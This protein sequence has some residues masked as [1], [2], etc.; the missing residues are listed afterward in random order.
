MPPRLC[1]KYIEAASA[2][3]AYC[4]YAPREDVEVVR[5]FRLLAQ[6]YLSQSNYNLYKT[7]TD[8][9]ILSAKEQLSDTV[10]AYWYETLKLA[11]FHVLYGSEIAY[12]SKF[13]QVQYPKFIKPN[14][15]VG[16]IYAMWCNSQLADY[17]MY[18]DQYNEAL[19]SQIMATEAAKNLFGAISIPYVDA[20]AKR[21]ELEIYSG[22]YNQASVSLAEADKYSYQTKKNDIPAL[23]QAHLR[24]ARVYKITGNPLRSKKHVSEV[25]LLTNLLPRSNFNMEVLSNLQRALASYE[26][27]NINRADRIVQSTKVSTERTIGK[28]QRILLDIYLL[29]AE[30]GLVSGNFSKTEGSLKQA[31]SLIPENSFM[32][33]NWLML[34]SDY[35]LAISDVSKSREYLSYSDKLVV[36]VLGS[37][38]LFRTA[39]LT[40]QAAML[41][42]STKPDVQ[43]I[44]KLYIQA[45]IIAAKALGV[46]NPIFIQIQQK[47]AE[48]YIQIGQYDKANTILEEVRKFWLAMYGENHLNV[49]STVMLLGKVYYMQS[50]YEQAATW[51]GQSANIYKSIF[52]TEHPEYIKAQSQLA[53]VAYM[54][55]DYGKSVN[56]M[57]D[58][59]PKCLDYTKKYFPNLSF[60][61]KS[62]FWS[63]LKDD[64][65]FYTFLV[66]EKYAET[67]P[68]LLGVLY[69]TVIN[70]KAL[71]LSSDIKLRKQILSSKDLISSSFS[72]SK[73]ELA[74][75]GIYPDKLQSSLEELE[76]KMSARSE[77]FARSGKDKI[78]SWEDIRKVLT[79]NEVS[80]EML[81]YRRF[82]K[83]FTDTAYYAELVLTAERKLSPD[84]VRLEEG[85]MLEK[86]YLKYYRNA[87]VT[88]S[89]DD[90]SYD[91]FWA[92]I[93]AKL[94]DG[95]TVYFSGEGVY[96]QLNVET[97]I[98]T[99]SG[100]YVLEQNNVVL[101]TNTKDL[102]GQV[103]PRPKDTEVYADFVVSGNTQFYKDSN[104]VKKS[105]D[106]L[107]GAEQEA[108]LV[109]EIIVKSGKKTVKM[110]N[111]VVTEDTI[112]SIKNPT[113]FHI[114]THGFFKESVAGNED[115]LSSN[116]LINSGLM[117]T[118][119]GDIADNHDN[120][121]VN[122]KEGIL[123][124]YESLDLNF[125]HTE[126][127]VLSACETG[128]GDVQLGEEVYGLQ[129]SFLVAGS[130]AI[131]LSLFKV[132]D[133][134]TQKLMMTFYTNWIRTGNMRQSFIDA[135]KEV[136]ASYPQ[137]I[138]WGAFVL[139]ESRPKRAVEAQM[140]AKK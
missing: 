59:V 72:L 17:Y 88:K 26:T 13:F 22:A 60:R 14:L 20:L 95:Y 62:K 58:I 119:S 24:I 83:V 12:A 18:K 120:G 107:A 5:I 140:W 8:S 105:I 84:F 78:I 74:E 135:K 133:E 11:S 42:K 85:S 128:R 33:S 1:P 56:L 106:N 15:T 2:Q 68:D 99:E 34:Q 139:I 44:E 104:Q 92:P 93:K 112:K 50:K 53:R 10:P 81:R 7:Y 91:Q 101:V 21:S 40:R 25:L 82:N 86:R 28:D 116:P 109:E 125:D 30:T 102:V 98:N 35:S 76:K 110:L 80:V 73:E 63:T 103:A 43:A 115:D 52:N 6:V 111:H 38:H 118:G 41:Y 27:G 4:R 138:Y 75:Q 96:N 47:Q 9:V 67:R 130:K 57:S 61:Q 87:V 37:N 66:M 123:T 134:V 54:Q 49:A 77:A 65:E 46:R 70:T 36:S 117:L 94:P 129:R 39:T 64:F 137:P 97:L 3:I 48:F 79:Y 19:A 108:H 16:S 45:D 90:Y 121:Y 132:N 89:A 127:V 113:V 122:Q 124:A 71:L 23:I 114:A 136:K 100:K 55:R 51:F 69:N 31:K 126:L 131:I 32:H 29:D